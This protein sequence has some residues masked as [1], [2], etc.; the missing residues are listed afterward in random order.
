MLQFLKSAREN[1]YVSAILAAFAKPIH[2]ACIRL[3]SQIERK[4]RRNSAAVTLPNGRI[5]RVARDAGV[6]MAS[7]LFWKGLDGFEVQTSETMRF[8]FERASTFVDVGANYG[9]YS[10]L[11]ATWNTHLR[12]VSFEPVPQIHEG[13][14]RNIALNNM[15]EQVSAHRLALSDQTGTATLYLPSNAEGRDFETTGTLVSNSWQSKKHSPEIVVETAR[16]DDFERTHPMK[17]DLVKIDVEGHEIEVLQG[18]DFATWQ[19]RLLMI[20]DHVSDLRKHRFLQRNGYRL[21]RRVGNN[22]WYVPGTNTVT[23]APV[24]RREIMRKYYLA[25]PFRVMRN[26]SRS[27]RRSLRDLWGGR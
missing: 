22:G 10:L 11:G 27:L 14:K 4:V 6:S 7:L 1:Y 20:E 18:F 21:I 23:V 26:A 13:F 9:F 17:L 19:P 3:S 25:L 12:V 16:F 5:L 15:Q 8:F 24:E 2:G